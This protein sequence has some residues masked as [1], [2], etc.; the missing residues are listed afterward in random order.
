M[1]GPPYGRYGGP[2]QQSDRPR[3]GAL[4]TS[5]ARQRPRVPRSGSSVGTRCSGRCPGDVEDHRVPATPRRPGRRTC[6]RQ[7]PRKYARVS[8]GGSVHR[9]G[10]RLVVE[11]PLAS[12][13]ARTSRWYRPFSGRMSAHCRSTSPSFGVV[14]VRA[15]RARGSPRAARAWPP[16]PARRA[17]LH[18]V[19]A[20]PVEHATPSASS[21]SRVCS[22]PSPPTAGPDVASR[23]RSKYSHCRSSGG[24][25]GGRRR[26]RS[27]CGQRRVVADRLQGGH[28]LVAPRGRADETGPRSSPA[29]AR[30]CRP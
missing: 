10:D 1:P 5:V 11:Q 15:R 16:S 22:S 21:T 9:P 23:P 2:T 28:R 19:A 3:P 12:G 27:R 4:R 7:R 29:P 13:R 8:D 30:W 18:R 20:E 26:S 6:R 14:P 17:Q 24:Q 25:R